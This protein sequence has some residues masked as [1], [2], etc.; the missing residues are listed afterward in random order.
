MKAKIKT[1]KGTLSRVIRFVA[2]YRGAL[3]LSVICAAASAVLSLYIPILTGNAIDAALGKGM[4]D[5]DSLYAALV[6]FGICLAVIVPAQWIMAI[7]NNRI[8]FGVVRDLRMAAFRKLQKLPIAYIDSTP[9]G[10][11]VSRIISDADRFSDGLVLGFSQLLTGLITIVGTI[12]FM[13]TLNWL[14]TLVVVL[15]TPLSLVCASFIARRTYSMFSQQSKDN[16]SLTAVIDETVENQK[17]IRAYGYEGEMGR[18]FAEA[19]ERLRQSS[20]RA[21]FYSSLTNPVTRFVNSMVYAVTAGAG[22]ILAIAQPSFTAGCLSSF[23]IYANQ[24]TKPFNEISGVLTELQGALAGAARIFELLDTPDAI[25]EGREEMPA[26]KV[27]GEIRFERVS[28]SYDES[29]PLIKEL[30][31]TAHPG[32]RIAIVGPT[33]CGKTT[34]INLI[35]RF[36]DPQS[37]EI[38]LD[39]VDI[40]DMPRANLRSLCGMVLQDTWIKNGTVRDNIVMGRPG[41]TDEEMIAAAKACHAH[42]F[43]KRLKNGYDTVIGDRDGSLSQ[44]QRQL[45]CICRLM[46]EPPPV[47]ILDEATSSIDTR[48]EMKISDAFNKLMKGRTSFIV[49][50]RLQTI[51]NADMILVMRNG[52]VVE[53]G[54]HREL[55]A[56]KGFYAELYNSQF[57]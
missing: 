4:V 15:L 26:D 54:T 19:N 24:Y 23:L 1:P 35:M 27:K 44:G 34:L 2:R 18:S 52:D 12:I 11:T 47:L 10:D 42:G 37:G 56:R 41:T 45:I 32:Q 9:R 20:L 17:L 57:K 38:T 13:F 31:F 8:A 25:N 51:R 16:G 46:L 30:S 29:R 55:L 48:T 40:K 6:K 43:I 22:A 14:I 36:Y 21:I 33:G 49:A 5:F 53:S 39:G 3:I 50:H 7:C 28:F